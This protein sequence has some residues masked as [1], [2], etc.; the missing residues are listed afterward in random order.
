[1]RTTNTSK[2]VL[3]GLPA[4]VPHAALQYLAHTEIGLPIRNLRENLDVMPRL[5]CAKFAG[6][7]RVA[8]IP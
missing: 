3:A 7:K 1:M 6:S 4:W 8:T 2:P 5:Y